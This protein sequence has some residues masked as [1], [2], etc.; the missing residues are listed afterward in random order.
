MVR[1][2]AAGS[3][4][5]KKRVKRTTLS[6][7]VEASGAELKRACHGDSHSQAGKMAGACWS[8]QARSNAF[9]A[10]QTCDVRLVKPTLRGQ[11]THFL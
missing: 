4:L 5:N 11:A 1:C 6:M 7:A 10:R 3:P 2:V 9:F 8:H